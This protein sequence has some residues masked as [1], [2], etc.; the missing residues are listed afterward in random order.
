MTVW[1]RARGFVSGRMAWNTLLAGIPAIVA[2]TLTIG[3]GGEQPKYA[4]PPA[5]SFTSTRASLKTGDAAIELQSAAVAPDFFVKAGVQPLIGRF[6][7]EGDAQPSAQPVL[8]LSHELWTTRLGSSPAIIGQTIELDGRPAIIV[9][10]APAGF[11]LPDA[12]QLWTARRHD[13]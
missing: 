1:H 13:R 3:C 2:A 10:V 8:V 4:L 9:G 11:S 5:D 12:A 6:V 7:I